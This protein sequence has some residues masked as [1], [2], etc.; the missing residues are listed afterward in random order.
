MTELFRADISRLDEI[1]AIESE[2]F[3]PPWSRDSMLSEL[4]SPDAAV[5][6]TVCSG[7]V[8]GFAVMHR[9]GDEAELYQIA[10]S[11]SF[12]RRGAA[13]MLVS[14]LKHEAAELGLERIFLEVRAGNAPA[15][16]LYLKHGFMQCGLRRDYYDGPTEDAAIMVMEV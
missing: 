13:G 11:P 7:T 9:S 12:R 2:C 3:S 4:T 1:M 6:C 16:A 8:T 5:F 15:V 14:A 10:V